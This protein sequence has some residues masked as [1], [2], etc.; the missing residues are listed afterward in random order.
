MKWLIPLVFLTG[1]AT[2]KVPEPV[3][4]V[5]EVKVPISEPCIPA[6]FDRNSPEYVDSDTAL[7][8]AF[9]AAYRYQLLWAGRAQR[10]AREKEMSAA[11][12]GCEKIGG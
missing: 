4:V 1:C 12:S 6:T 3:I 9:D 7:K 8:S 11:L 10:I 5:K 2:S